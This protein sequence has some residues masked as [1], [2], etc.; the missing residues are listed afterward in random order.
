MKA[1]TVARVCGEV[2]QGSSGRA[3]YFLF[4]AIGHP[5]RVPTKTRD[6][7]RAL[8]RVMNAGKLVAAH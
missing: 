5:S 6:K 3:A 2:D 1:A 4:R 7:D 8:N